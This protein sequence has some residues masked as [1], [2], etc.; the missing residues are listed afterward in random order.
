MA[1]MKEG[2][3]A[4]A[5]AT[6]A[7]CYNEARVAATSPVSQKEQPIETSA[8]LGYEVGGKSGKNRV[9]FFVEYHESHSEE[10]PATI[11]TPTV[12]MG[13]VWRRHLTGERAE[14]YGALEAFNMTEFPHVQIG[15][16]FNVDDHP[17]PVNTQGLGFGLGV[18]LG[19]ADIRLM[20]RRLLGSENIE[21]IV[22]SSVAFTF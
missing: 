5:L 12:T 20:Y 1:G 13:A 17:D 14:L 9:A 21:G 18:E 7:G 16:P 8:A 10:P 6:A 4:L 3:A 2:L 19:R 15:E 11:D 22:H